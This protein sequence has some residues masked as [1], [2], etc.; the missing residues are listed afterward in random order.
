MVPESPR[1]LLLKGRK[2][3]ALQ[4]L[5]TLAAGNGK[6][7]PSTIT[8][9]KAEIVERSSSIFD[10]FSFQS[11]FIRTAV[12]TSG[13]YEMYYC[14]VYLSAYLYNKVLLHVN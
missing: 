14:I 8:L 4:M 6:P 13:W 11:I 1:W 2:E 12:I 3:E 7:L 5:K 9:K 10:L